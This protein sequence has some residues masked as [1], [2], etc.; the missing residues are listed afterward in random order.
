MRADDAELFGRD[1]FELVKVDAFATAGADRAI[2]FVTREFGRVDMDAD[3]V[4]AKQLV[5]VQFAIGEHLLPALAFDFRMK[6]ACDFAGGFEGYYADA[7]VAGEVNEGGCHLS[8]IAILERALSEPASRDHADGVRGAAVDL[9]V[10]DE[11]LAVSAERVINGEGFESKEGHAD[12]EDLSGAHVT[13]D[14]FGLM[15]KS[16]Q[17]FHHLTSFAE[18]C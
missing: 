13:V 1:L 8:P 12:A 17:R 14:G 6:L 16:I 4:H 18:G 15:K 2:G 5:I 11:A 7:F 3:P 9:D 10:G